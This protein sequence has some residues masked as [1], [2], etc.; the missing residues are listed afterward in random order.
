[1]L[2]KTAPFVSPVCPSAFSGGQREFRIKRQTT[3]YGAE[4]QDQTVDFVDGDC[5]ETMV[6]N[7]VLAP[8]DYLTLTVMEQHALLQSQIGLGIALEET[9]CENIMMSIRPLAAPIVDISDLHVSGNVGFGQDDDSANAYQT[10]LQS[11]DELASVSVASSSDTALLKISAGYLNNSVLQL[12]ETDDPSD[13]GVVADISILNNVRREVE[14]EASTV[15]NDTVYTVVGETFFQ[16]LAVRNY[17]HDLLILRIDEN[18][19]DI[20]G[21]GDPFTGTQVDDTSGKLVLNGDASYCTVGVAAECTV[22]LQSFR[23]AAFSV[24]SFNSTAQV[25]VMAAEN[26]KSALN[27]ATDSRSVMHFFNDAATDSLQLERTEVAGLTM[28]LSD[29]TLYPDLNRTEF[30]TLTNVGNMGHLVMPGIAKFGLVRKTHTH[31]RALCALSARAFL[32]TSLRLGVP[33]RMVS[34]TG[35]LLGRRQTNKS[36]VPVPNPCRPCRP[37]PFFAPAR[38]SSSSPSR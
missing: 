28:D 20:D 16:N 36:M 11:S 5:A 9:V 29:P 13:S 38:S 27:L 34:A 1:M 12:K 25:T 23:E 18:V 21:D 8:V 24:V 26:Q 33:L 22:T 35:S 32:K 31:P 19:L 14:L 37:C 7:T 2:S 15:G 4:Y 6:I 30:F 3:D 10:L 17:D